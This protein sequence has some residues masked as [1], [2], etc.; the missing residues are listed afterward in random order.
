MPRSPVASPVGASSRADRRLAGFAF[1]A[2]FLGG[3]S[4]VSVPRFV[5]F[6]RFTTGTLG[7]ILGTVD[8]NPRAGGLGLRL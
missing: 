3:S 8:K 6:F 7:H 1:R 4:T 5:G 2:A